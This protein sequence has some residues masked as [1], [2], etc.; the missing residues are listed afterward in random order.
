MLTVYPSKADTPLL[1]KPN[2]D[3]YRQLSSTMQLYSLRNT[4]FTCYRNSVFHSLFSID[5]FLNLLI[6]GREV[7]QK[8]CQ[9]YNALWRAA[10]NFRGGDGNEFRSRVGDAW[11]I[12]TKTLPLTGREGR[13]DGMADKKYNDNIGGRMEDVGTI[14][15][16]LMFRLCETELTSDQRR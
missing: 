9:I 10:I 15:E 7:T 5:Y 3:A 16:Y 8:K 14:F 6:S 11:R 1:K 13:D 4:D 12:M 2:P